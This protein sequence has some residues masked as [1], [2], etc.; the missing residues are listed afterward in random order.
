VQVQR[1]EAADGR[2][3][4]VVGLDGQ[5]V[6]AHM[7]KNEREAIDPKQTAIAYDVVTHVASNLPG[8]CHL[9]RIGDGSHA[10]DPRDP[11]VGLATAYAVVK[12]PTL[13]PAN[14]PLP[15]HNECAF[16]YGGCL[17]PGAGINSGEVAAALA[18]LLE[19]IHIRRTSPSASASKYFNVIYAIDSAS[20]ADEMDGLWQSEDL[21]EVRC[22][23]IQPLVETWCHWRRELHELGG[24]FVFVKF[25]GHGGVAPMAAADACAKACLCMQPRPLLLTVHST[26]ATVVALPPSSAAQVTG[27]SARSAACLWAGTPSPHAVI[28]QYIPFFRTRL[29]RARAAR[30][31]SEYCAR[32]AYGGRRLVIDWARAGL[33]PPWASGATRWSAMLAHFKAGAYMY[34]REDGRATASAV[35]LAVAGGAALVQGALVCSCGYEGR[36]DAHHWLTGCP[37]G[38]GVAQRAAAASELRAVVSDVLEAAEQT[39]PALI[40]AVDKAAVVL[41]ESGPCCRPCTPGASDADWCEAVL[42]ALGGMPHPGRDAIQTAARRLD[43]ADRAPA[44]RGGGGGAVSGASGAA[45]VHPESAEAQVRR[46]IDKRL[47]AF[48]RALTPAYVEYVADLR[49]TRDRRAG[50]AMAVDVTP[51]VLPSVLRSQ[52]SVEALHD[53]REEGKARQAAGTTPRKPASLRLSLSDA[54]VRRYRNVLYC[55]PDVSDSDDEAS[56]LATAEEQAWEHQRD[57]AVE[58]RWARRSER[59]TEVAH[60]RDTRRRDAR[61]RDVHRLAHVQSTALEAEMAPPDAPP[62]VPAP[63]GPPPPPP[64]RRLPPPPPPPTAGEALRRAEARAA[65]A[66][67]AAV[68]ADARCAEAERA[69]ALANESMLEEYSDYHLQWA[70]AAL[71][72]AQPR[73]DALL[74]SYRYL[75]ATAGGLTTVEAEELRILERNVTVQD[76]LHRFAQLAPDV[77]GQ[78]RRAQ[79]LT[80]AKG[81]ANAFGRGRCFARAA[82]PEAGYTDA[83][84]KWRTT[85]LQGCPREVRLLLAGTFYHDLD[86]VNSL[87]IVAVQLDRLGLC[88]PKYLGMLRDYCD[89]R[90]HW[91]AEIIEFHD[92]PERM[93][94][95][96]TAR[97]VAKALLLRLLHGGTYAAWVEEFGLARRGVGRVTGAGLPKVLRLAVELGLARADAVARVRAR[98]PQWMARAEMAVRAKHAASHAGPRTPWAEARDA[99]RVTTT[100]FSYIIQDVEDACLQAARAELDRCGWLTHSLQQDGLLVERGFTA[101]HAAAL[102]LDGADGALARA[103]RAITEEVGGLQISMIEKP[104]HGAPGLDAIMCRLAR[105]LEAVPPPP[106][107]LNVSGRSHRPSGPEH[108]RSLAMR[109]QARTL[110]AANA[111]AEAAA[112][113]A[114]VGVARQG[115]AGMAEQ[116]APRTPS[117]PM[118]CPGPLPAP[119]PAA[120][121]FAEDDMQVDEGDEV[122]EEGLAAM[123]EIELEEALPAPAPSPPA[124]S[125]PLLSSPLLPSPPLP[126][127]LPADPGDA[128]VSTAS[129]NPSSASSQPVMEKKKKKRAKQASH[130][131]RQHEVKRVAWADR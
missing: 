102:P 85:T 50:T 21:A 24:H 43:G 71:R 103:M 120:V 30:A 99:E 98:D 105:P 97:D 74:D 55:P 108:A 38:P 113:A 44:D 41:C 121:A 131:M 114:D 26:L 81:G 57:A 52:A 91:F 47:C 123:E 119:A 6:T 16:A 1:L 13:Y 118:A 72:E 88:D 86:F 49:A 23:A 100:L 11:S 110:L 32:S 116:P 68:R 65:A 78:R 83:G 92:I 17:G 89:H 19:A 87:P 107:P 124:P 67:L 28:T 73:R 29:Q 36:L 126:S 60:A 84:G 8:G 93:G 80:Y 37:R 79:L 9:F 5:V 33:V 15:W 115:V 42:V 101:A 7:E 59:A 122:D 45:A 130:G 51:D 63:R 61:A 34:A 125:S 117:P 54:A 104:F 53:K 40:A 18:C 31:V 109:A 39:P 75:A 64:A 111:R 94:V 106:E 27:A 90:A 4:Q 69:A 48:W 12:G 127:P 46:A 76:A 70:L 112:C 35:A 2:G 25:P 96:D 58:L 77:D 10:P 22:S 20:C 14:A 128:Q 62:C 129:S 3:V 82:A 95:H 66:A 56:R